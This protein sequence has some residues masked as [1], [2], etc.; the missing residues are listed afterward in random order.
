MNE[1]ETLNHAQLREIY[2]EP[3][4]LVKNAYA[5]ILEETTKRFIRACSFVVISSTNQDGDLDISPRG[6]APGFISIIDDNH[7]AFLDKS[8]NNKIQTLTNLVTSSQVGLMFMI[9]GV[10]DAVRVYGVAK[11]IVDEEKILA[12]GG[13][14]KRDKS[15]IAVEITKVFPHC[16]SAMNHAG[17]WK[18]DGWIDPKASD[19]PSLMEMAQNLPKT[20]PASDN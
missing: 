16:G 19:V 9:P 1:S 12:M 6:G 7:I 15:I 10:S 20:R 4:E 18:P 3:K 13:N 2:A 14:L 8:G 5:F 17:L 11:F